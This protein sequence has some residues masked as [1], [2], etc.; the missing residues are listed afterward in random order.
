MKSKIYDIVLEYLETNF[1]D[2][3]NVT[4][5]YG[6][7]ELDFRISYAVKEHMTLIRSRRAKVL[8]SVIIISE[9][10]VK[11]K[12]QDPFD[13][14]YFFPFS[15]SILEEPKRLANHI[16]LIHTST[17]AHENTGKR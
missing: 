2:D 15:F 17:F 6:Y 14:A 1:P 5:C 8:D 9:T 7:K 12:E 11:I 10:E 13:S 4:I 3:E 16:H